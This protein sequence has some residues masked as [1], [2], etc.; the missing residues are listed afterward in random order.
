MGGRLGTSVLFTAPPVVE[1]LV[2][3]PTAAFPAFVFDGVVPFGFVPVTV[4][5]L[6]LESAAV[7][8]LEFAPGLPDRLLEPSCDSVKLFV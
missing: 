7:P 2:E 3:F 8:V 4:P 1:S 5:K 6:P